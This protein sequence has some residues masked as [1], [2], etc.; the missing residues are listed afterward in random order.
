MPT[1]DPLPVWGLG[2]SQGRWGG[3]WQASK[4]AGWMET[5][6]RVP[7]ANC[8]PTIP[9]CLSGLITAGRRVWK[10]YVHLCLLHPLIWHPCDG[11]L[12]SKRALLALF[13]QSSQGVRVSH[14]HSGYGTGI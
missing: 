11:V 5:A 2:R 4:E 9:T 12:R 7:T 1:L 13:L 10:T 8:S 6:S 3:V 14:L